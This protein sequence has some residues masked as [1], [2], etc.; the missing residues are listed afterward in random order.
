MSWI[1][2]GSELCVGRDSVVGIVIAMGW[3]IW[4]SNPGGGEIFTP[5]HIDPGAHPASCTMGT[6]SLPGGKT[7][8]SLR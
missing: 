7:A 5:I 8:G 2:E 6:V 3:V 4:G 1:G